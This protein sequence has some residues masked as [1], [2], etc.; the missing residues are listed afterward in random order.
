MTGVLMEPCAQ[1]AREVSGHLFPV[2]AAI[3]DAPRVLHFR[4]YLALP[5]TTQA[6]NA[7]KRSHR[8]ANAYGLACGRAAANVIHLSSSLNLWSPSQCATVHHAGIIAVAEHTPIQVCQIFIF[9]FT[10]LFYR[11][12]ML[13]KVCDKT[14]HRF[15]ETS[16]FSRNHRFLILHRSARSC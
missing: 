8:K 2:G 10:K 9:P 15:K 13:N 16:V 5:L 7:A 4:A 11:G 12:I 14:T 1:T 6:V 3:V